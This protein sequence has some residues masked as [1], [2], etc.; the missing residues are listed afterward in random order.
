MSEVYRRYTPQNPHT[1]E[2]DVSAGMWTIEP[3]IDVKSRLEVLLRQVRA[4]GRNYFS[5]WLTNYLFGLDCDCN[6][7]HHLSRC[8]RSELSAWIIEHLRFITREC[9]RWHWAAHIS[10]NTLHHQARLRFLQLVAEVRLA[11]E[12][13]AEEGKQCFLFYSY[14][15]TF[16]IH[17]CFICLSY[18][19]Y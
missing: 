3:L 2:F 9:G 5:V 12:R 14:V 13:M 18:F 16:I 7:E 4:E 8:S 10:R 17:I 6:Y 15:A 11:A 19:I 1:F